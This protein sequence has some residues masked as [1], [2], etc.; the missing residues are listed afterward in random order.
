MQFLVTFE[1]LFAVFIE[2]GLTLSCEIMFDESTLLVP[3]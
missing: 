1:Q 2:A 3:S